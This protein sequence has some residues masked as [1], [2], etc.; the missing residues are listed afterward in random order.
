MKKI[1]RI[2]TVPISLKNLLKGQPKFMSEYYE[3]VGVTSPGDAIKDIEDE[4]GIRVIEIEMTRSITPFKDLAS[5]IKLIKLLKASFIYV[6]QIN[7][8]LS[9]KHF[10]NC[11]FEGKLV[12]IK[13]FYVYIK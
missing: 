6:L 7:F 13:R 10:K 5:L 3:V 4:E 8:R 9:N 11:L 1:I 12:N 2:T